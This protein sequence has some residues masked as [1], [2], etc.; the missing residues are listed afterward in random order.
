MTRA[1]TTPP[2]GT[3]GLAGGYRLGEQIGAGAMGAVYEAARPDGKLVAV[4]LLHARW[5]AEP[6]AVQRFRN[7]GIAGLR[8]N[9]PHLVSVLGRGET[10]TGI[11]FIVMPRIR[12]ESLGARLYREG[13]L[14]LHRAATIVR[15]ILTG[16]DALHSA[17]VIH[18][19]VKTDNILVA[20]SQDDDTAVLTDLGLATPWLANS[21]ESL[22]DGATVSGTPEYMAP[23]LIR[24]SPP[25]PATDIYAAG[26]VLYELIAGMP[27]VSGATSAEILRRHLSDD[28]T[29]PSLLDPR[30]PIPP[31]LDG[32]VMRS[33][34]KDPGKRFASAAAFAAALGAAL[35]C[36]GGRDRRADRLRWLSR[37]APT[38][39]WVH[40]ER[41]QV[42]P[43]RHCLTQG[44][45]NGLSL[46]DT[47]VVTRAVESRCTSSRT[48]PY[49]SDRCCHAAPCFSPP[50]RSRSTSTAPTTSS[51]R[52]PP[53]HSRRR[54][55]VSSAAGST[56]RR[57]RSPK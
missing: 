18:G 4:K 49:P 27:P 9:H 22:P 31:I 46:R 56:S 54:W 51:S 14:Q 13:T 2:S 28:I 12:G 19:D 5:L 20:T 36:L 41:S 17:G 45:P 15:Q 50:A 23:E 8:V 1:W 43:H 7:E 29:P 25:T 34:E 32:I 53:I 6:R 33:L 24:G 16:L 47:V 26:V 35:P 48:V 52:Y 44:T 10:A 39:E 57:Q 3:G 40:P 30:S 42:A 38:Q 55:S 37:E 21:D 11:P